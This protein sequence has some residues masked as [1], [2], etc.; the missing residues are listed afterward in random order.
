[1]RDRQVVALEIVV[2]VHLPVA[3]DRV[4]A[5]FD[6]THGAQVVAAGLDLVWNRADPV[7]ERFRVRVEVGEHEGPERVDPDGHKA[8][9][10]LVEVLGAFHLARGLQPAVEA[11]DPAVVTA[12]QRLAVAASR[13][14]LRRAVAAHVV[15]TVQ[16]AVLRAC[17]Q[18]RLVDDGRGLEVARSGEL[19]DVSHQLPGA[20]E[21]SVLLLLE[22]RRVAVHRGRQGVG[23]SNLFF[24]LHRHNSITHGSGVRQRCRLAAG[25]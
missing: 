11:V 24:D 3:L 6:R 25:R 2:D 16:G 17:Q 20:G 8:E 12:L 18:D 4:V 19:V 5:A 21:D 10:G 1:M 7:R 23:P 15:E 14:D 13:H 9:V 22:N